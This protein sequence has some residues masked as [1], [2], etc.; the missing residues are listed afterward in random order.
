MPDLIPT[1]ALGGRTPARVVAGELAL[2]ENSSLGLAS[3]ALRRDG[4]QPVP[5]GLSLPEPGGHV[6]NG[7]VGAFW[8]APGQWMIEGD[9]QAESDFAAIVKAEAPSCSVTEQTDGFVVFEIRSSAGETPIIRLM[10]K[11]VN[12]DPARF[13]PSSATRTGLEHMTVFI[14]RRAV[15]RM[16]IIG[17]RSAAG[18]LWHALEVAVTRLAEAKA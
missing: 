11:L 7:S 16:A 13:G 14:L 6:T 5:F 10:E 17:M 8:L 2:E 12:L 1:T 9:G 18:S 3:I 4:T 15:D